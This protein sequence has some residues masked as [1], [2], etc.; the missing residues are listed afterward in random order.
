M[1][2]VKYHAR[3]VPLARRRLYAARAAPL[4]PPHGRIA[5]D[6]LVFSES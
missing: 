3:S 4:E 6:A 5:T 2:M 1:N